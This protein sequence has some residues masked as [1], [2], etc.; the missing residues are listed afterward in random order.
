MDNLDYIENY[1]TNTPG[2]ELAREFE[3]RITT[4]P[5]FAEEVAF[6]LAAHEVSREASG[7]E[8]KERFK[9]TYQRNRTVRSVPVKRLIYYI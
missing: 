8:K 7:I 6:Y 2:T 4:D 3:E 5:G 1:F 9:E